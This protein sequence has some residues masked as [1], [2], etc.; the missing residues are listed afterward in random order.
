MK[1]FSLALGF[2]ITALSSALPISVLAQQ[3]PGDLILIGELTPKPASIP[4]FEQE[5][6]EL[7]ASRAAS[8]MPTALSS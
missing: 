1:S 2:A 6:K 5:L 4:P 8:P 7:A 3:K